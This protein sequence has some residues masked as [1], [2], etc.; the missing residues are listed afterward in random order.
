MAELSISGASTKDV[1]NEDRDFEPTADMLVHDFD[2][3]QTMEEEEKLQGE[4]NFSN[5]IDDLTREGEM[6][7]HE[8]LKMYGYGVAEPA[9]SEDEG[10]EEQDASE[11]V[12]SSSAPVNIKT[13]K[14]KNENGRSSSEA[15]PGQSRTPSTAQLL[16][17]EP[18]SY[19]DGDADESEDEDYIPSEEW[20]KEVKVGPMYQ[21]ETPIELCKYKDNEKVYENEDQLLWNPELLPENEVVEFLSEASKRVGEQTE[22]NAVPEI[23]PIK[24]NEEALYE[25]IKCNYNKEEALKRLKF[26]PKSVKDELPAWTEEERREFEEWDGVYENDFNS[27]QADKHF[28]LW[29]RK[30]DLHSSVTV[31][32][33]QMLPE[34]KNT[35]ARQ[36]ATAPTGT[37]NCSRQQ[38]DNEPSSTTHNGADSRSV[39]PTSSCGSDRSP[40]D[41]QVP[42]SP[43]PKCSSSNTDAVR[44]PREDEDDEERVVKKP[45]TEMEFLTAAAV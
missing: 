15:S 22:E 24:D 16:C 14:E 20:K 41:T 29:R 18:S 42:S 3:E 31:S 32:T 37:S 23:P 4:T 19:F 5:E 11:N 12:Q 35:E 44:R 6:P 1:Q 34:M 36:A 26:N 21:A 2:D 30:P 7:L 33:E 17:S 25:L 9:D 8:L 45:K 10:P 40:S 38:S 27:M 13:K 39:K 43:D 28:K